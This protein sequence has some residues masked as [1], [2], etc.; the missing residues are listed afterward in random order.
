MNA[1]TPNQQQSEFN[2]EN[3]GANIT[4]ASRGPPRKAIVNPYDKK[5]SPVLQVDPLP[6][7]VP[8][9]YSARPLQPYQQVCQPSKE[10]LQLAQNSQSSTSSNSSASNSNCDDVTVGNLFSGLFDEELSRQSAT[11]TWKRRDNGA[12]I[13]K[14][15]IPIN[16][17]TEE[18]V[19]DLATEV[20]RKVLRDKELRKQIVLDMLPEL[21]KCMCVTYNDPK[22]SK[23]RRSV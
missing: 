9:V 18:L 22:P 12:L 4:P 17:I 20:A 5:R 23:K 11:K 3:A 10:P 15:E 19:T 13:A 8:G 16:Q 21:A 1:M 14:L 2:K 7:F 6:D